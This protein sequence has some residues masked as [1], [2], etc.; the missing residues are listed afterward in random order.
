MEHPGLRL[1][2]EDALVGAQELVVTIE[3]VQMIGVRPDVDSQYFLCLWRTGRRQTDEHLMA[4]QPLA[5]C[6]QDARLPGGVHCRACL[7]HRD[8]HATDHCDETILRSQGRIQVIGDESVRREPY[9]WIIGCEEGRGA[10]VY[11][12]IV[13]ELLE[14]LSAHP[15]INKHQIACPT[16]RR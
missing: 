10:R 8:C 16:A 4:G 2:D 7:L 12:R 5:V 6:C 14:P 9:H 15:L 3:S 13:K 11:L 1:C